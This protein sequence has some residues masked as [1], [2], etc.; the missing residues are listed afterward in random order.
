SLSA[1]VLMYPMWL[2]YEGATLLFNYWWL[3]SPLSSS[4][5]SNGWIIAF[6][7]WL[8]GSTHFAQN[9][10]ALS[11]LSITSP[12]TYSIASLVK[13]IFVITASI[14]WFGQKT[15]FVQ[16]VGILLTFMGLHLY[17]RA[18][19]DVDKKERKVASG[20]ERLPMTRMRSK[21]IR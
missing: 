4:S 10:L 18:K 13:R 2:Y 17:N 1:F 8:N 20:G 9:I 15:T 21:S 6:Y 5:I 16:G 3:D 12:V 11:I 14:I 19:S 7:F